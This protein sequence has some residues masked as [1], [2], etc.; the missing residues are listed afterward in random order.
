MDWKPFF[1]TFGMLFLAEIGDKT[2]LVV[3]MQAAKFQ[4]PWMVL[5]G[6]A[7]A[8]TLVS[9]LGVVVGQ[10]CANCLPEDLLRWIAGVA[11]VVIGVLVLFRVL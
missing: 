8:L 1:V 7:L 10:V 2:Q 5:A 6:A 4:K 11:F 9:A 3:I